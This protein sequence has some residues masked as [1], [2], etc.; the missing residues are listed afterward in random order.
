[1]ADRQVL[2]SL[3]SGRR[4]TAGQARTALHRLDVSF[5][6][7][8]ATDRHASRVLGA[9]VRARLRQYGALLCHDGR[10]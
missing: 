6:C 7:V 1:M 8:P 10:T 3:V 4:V 5:A 9:A 2:L